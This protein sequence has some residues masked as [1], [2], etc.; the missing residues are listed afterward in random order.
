MA[1]TTEHIDGS[2]VTE[3]FKDFGGVLEVAKRF[4][5]PNVKSVRLFKVGR[6]DSCPCGSGR[7]FKKCCIGK[8]GVI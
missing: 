5:Q 2:K 8:E 4:E 3:L 6:N 7:K 1:A